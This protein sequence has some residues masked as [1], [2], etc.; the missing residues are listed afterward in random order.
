MKS[1]AGLAERQCTALVKRL[2]RG[3]EYHTLLHFADVAQLA[4]QR[5]RNAPFGGSNPL[6]CSICRRRITVVRDFGKVEAT[7]QHRPVA[8]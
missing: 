4:Q 1:N 7:V 2:L 5:T 3:F 6:V 8:P